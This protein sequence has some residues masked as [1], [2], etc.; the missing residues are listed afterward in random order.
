VSLTFQDGIEGYNYAFQYTFNNQTFQSQSFDQLEFEL[1]SR[2]R[3]HTPIWGYAT[4]LCLQN[5]KQQ[6]FVVKF[7]ACNAYALDTFAFLLKLA[8]FPEDPGA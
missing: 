1:W 8:H 2:D 3:F 6:T 7:L 5:G 4:R